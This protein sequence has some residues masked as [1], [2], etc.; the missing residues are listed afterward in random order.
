MTLFVRLLRL[1]RLYKPKYDILVYKNYRPVGRIGVIHPFR[2]LNIRSTKMKVLKLHLDSIRFWKDRGLVLPN[3]LD[4]ITAPLF[5]LPK[6]EMVK[7]NHTQF[8]SH[9][10][11][12]SQGNL[13]STKFF[14]FVSG[15][16]QGRAMLTCLK[17]KRITHEKRI[18]TFVFTYN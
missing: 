1:G 17:K 9:K 12:V 13:K 10:S 11:L 5:I 4:N 6:Y 7:L 18:F 8:D 3:W 14:N 15:K 2:D 16:V